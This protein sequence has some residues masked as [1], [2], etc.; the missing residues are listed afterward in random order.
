MKSLK[1]LLLGLLVVSLVG[2]LALADSQPFNHKSVAGVKPFLY[3]ECDGDLDF[4][5]A[6]L[7]QIAD[8]ECTDK[9]KTH[10]V[11]C[12]LSTNSNLTISYYVSPYTMSGGY[13]MET[14]LT[15]DHKSDNGSWDDSG[16]VAVKTAFSGSIYLVRGKDFDFKVKGCANFELK[17]N[18]LTDHSGSYTAKLNITVY[19]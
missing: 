2:I 9:F 15:Y 16:T 4:D 3:Y 17:R 10:K 6:D 14:Y 19:Y 1:V 7:A 11:G 8:P 13:T 5:A 12:K 18:G